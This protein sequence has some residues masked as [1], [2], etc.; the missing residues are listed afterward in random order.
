MDLGIKNRVALVAAASTGLG[1]AVAEGLAAEGAR[2]AICARNAERLEQTASELA[3]TRGAKVFAR[4]LDVTDSAAVERFVAAV[5][6]EYGELDICVSNAGGPP[7]RPFAQTS[8]RDWRDAAELNLLAHVAFARAALPAMQPRQWGRFL[9]V[10]S[11]SVRQPIDGLV[12]SN[13]IRAGVLGLTRSLANEYGR[14]NILVN[15]IAPGYTLTQRLREL[16]QARARAAGCLPEQAE[17]EWSRATALGRLADP[18][19]FADA[20]VFLCSERA[21]YI[22]GQTLVVDGGFYKG[23]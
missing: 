20:A 4:A 6:A 2:L 18:K 13:V 5:V 23:L 10:S 9:M 19:E 15:N 3:Q 22:T 12:L 17:M 7:A 21:S 8:M 14:D 16:A 11:V 1:R